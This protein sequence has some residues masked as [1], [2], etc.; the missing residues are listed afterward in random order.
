MSYLITLLLLFLSFVFIFSGKKATKELVFQK[1]RMSNDQENRVSLFFHSYSPEMKLLRAAVRF[2]TNISSYHQSLLIGKKTRH[3]LGHVIQEESGVLI[4]VVK[5]QKKTLSYCEVDN[6]H[7]NQYTRTDDGKPYIADLNSG[8]GILGQF[9][10][11]SSGASDDYDMILLLDQ[12]SAIWDEFNTVHFNRNDL[13]LSYHN[14]NYDEDGDGDRDGIFD[15]VEDFSQLVHLTCK[16]N[17]LL[18]PCEVQLENKTHLIIDSIAY[19]NHSLT[20]DLNSAFNYMPIAIYAHWTENRKKQFNIE[21]GYDVKRESTIVLPVGGLEFIIHEDDELIIGSDLIHHFPRVAYSAGGEDRRIRVWY[22]YFIQGHTDRHYWVSTI[23]VLINLV[24]FIGIFYWGTSYNYYILDYLIHFPGISR[25]RFFFAMKQ[26]PLELLLLC[27]YAIQIIL[28]LVFSWN[29]N[30]LAIFTYN[31][32]H[33]D[34]R[35]ILFILYLSYHFIVLVFVLVHGGTS[36]IRR[37]LREWVLKPWIIDRRQVKHRETEEEASDRIFSSSLPLLNRMIKTKLYHHVVRQFHDKVEEIPTFILILRNQTLVSLMFLSLSVSYN[38]YSEFS[39]MPLMQIV[40]VT[41]LLFFFRIRYAMINLV[42]L[43]RFEHPFTENSGYFIYLVIDAA[44][45]IFYLS[46]SLRPIYLNYFNAVNSGYSEI[47][48]L[49][50]AITMLGLL[51]II[52]VYLVYSRITVYHDKFI[53]LLR[54]K[55]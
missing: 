19:A 30:F 6:I 1:T 50:Y 4:T 20:I 14:H 3:T 10:A 54:M 37:A 22:Y 31:N 48:V 26:I 44:L 9:F 2:Y 24:T 8:L 21:I 34:R 51:Y 15:N 45:F 16:E 53:D 38:Y 29:D 43:R 32:A 35:K 46:L 28:V 36:S 47:T 7:N 39:T 25:T 23:L 17:I 52:A 11:S 41:L 49:F 33:T 13:T 42:F 18:T 12:Y 5:S 40:G 55:A 27:L